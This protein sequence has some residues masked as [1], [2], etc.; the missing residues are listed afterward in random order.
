MAISSDPKITTTECAAYGSPRPPLPLRDFG[1]YHDY[2][3]VS[4]GNAAHTQSTQFD[5]AG[6]PDDDHDYENTEGVYEVI[7]GE[8]D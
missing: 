8:T 6:D 4:E 7:P 1:D 2:E 5:G 3:V